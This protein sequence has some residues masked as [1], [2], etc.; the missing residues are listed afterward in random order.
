MFCGVIEMVG[1]IY[2]CVNLIKGGMEKYVIKNLIFKFS[3]IVFKYDDYLIFEGIF[4]DEQGKQYYLDVYIVYCQVCFNVIE[5]F[6]KFGY[7]GVQVYLLFG[8]VL[9]QGYISGVV[10]VFNVCVILWLFIDIFD[11]DFKFGVD[12]L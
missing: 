12:G 5:Y 8:C 11:F 6:K 1:W 3:K 9:V 4:V 7:I 10:D 2:M